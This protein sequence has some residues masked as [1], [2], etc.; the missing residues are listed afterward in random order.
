MRA[1]QRFGERILSGTG[2]KRKRQFKAVGRKR[3]MYSQ[4]DHQE[5]KKTSGRQVCCYEEKRD[6][7]RVAL[8]GYARNDVMVAFSGGVDSALLLRMA[9]EAAQKQ[10][11]RVYAVTMQTRLHPL[12]EIREAEALAAEIGA[13]HVVIPV[14]ELEDAGIG[15]NPEDRCYRCKKY[16][17]LRILKKADE[18]KAAVVLEGTNEDDLHVYRPGIRAIRELGIKSPLADAGMTKEEVRRLAAEYNMAVASKP[19]APCLATRFPY[20]TE[21]TCDKLK[22]VGEGEAFL[23]SLGLRNVRLR[24]HDTIARIEVDAEEF[25]VIIGYRDKIINVLNELGYSYV[26]LDLAGFRSGSMD[27]GL[28]QKQ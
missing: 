12:G 21:L 23:T 10:G 17:F 2:S 4:R 1:Q 27:I 25:P 24:V 14:D 28:D 20:G 6:S 15:N 9:V 7:L 3:E 22:R 13:E 5:E 18:R 26:T 19:A 11:S 16:L 8:A